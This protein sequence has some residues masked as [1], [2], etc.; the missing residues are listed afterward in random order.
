MQASRKTRYPED[1]GWNLQNLVTTVL[2]HIRERPME[3][4]VRRANKNIALFV[5]VGS[6][7]I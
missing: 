2:T 4:C 1:I 5:K 7:L 6:S 3:E